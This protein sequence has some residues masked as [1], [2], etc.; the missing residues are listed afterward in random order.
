RICLAPRIGKS[1]EAPS[2]SAFRTNRNS[3]LSTCANSLQKLRTQRI[4]KGAPV[5]RITRSAARRALEP[6][7]FRH[8][9]LR[10]RG[11]QNRSPL[12][13][14]QVTEPLRHRA[15]ERGTPRTSERT[16]PTASA[17]RPESNF[18]RLPWLRCRS[19]HSTKDRRRSQQR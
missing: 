8:R 14:T 9:V 2:V 6:D 3:L 17:G 10:K 1:A 11:A 4:Q 7:A 12:S 16:A 5:E 18:G 19:R 15:A 13:R